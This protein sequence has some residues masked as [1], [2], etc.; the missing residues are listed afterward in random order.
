MVGSHPDNKKAPKFRGLWC[1]RELNQRHT[2]FQ[3]VA[4]PTELQHQRWFEAANIHFF[5]TLGR[6]L[7]IFYKQLLVNDV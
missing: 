4:L 7:K 2:D 3:S 5:L 6:L 1:W